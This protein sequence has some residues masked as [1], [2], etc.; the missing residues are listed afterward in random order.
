M[1]SWA[2]QGY[3]PAQGPNSVSG[4]SRI[5][6]HNLLVTTAERE[7][8][9]AHSTS[10]FTSIQF[11]LFVTKQFSSNLNVGL[12]LDRNLDGKQAILGDAR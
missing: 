8:S 11:I 7:A 12:N 9:F 4:N 6:S 3:G 10:P 5:Q 1:Q 2:F